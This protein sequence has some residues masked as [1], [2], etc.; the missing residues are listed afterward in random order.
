MAL[1]VTVKGINGRYRLTECP[2]H[3]QIQPLVQWSLHSI[4]VPFLVGVLHYLMHTWS[5]R[6]LL[7]GMYS[8]MVACAVTC[9]LSC[10]T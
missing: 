9:C 5:M 8:G 1:K 10:R 3:R 4:C 2:R 7:A 6:L